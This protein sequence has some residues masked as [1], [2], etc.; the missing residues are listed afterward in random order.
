M[1]SHFRNFAP[2]LVGLFFVTVGASQAHAQITREVRAHLDHSFVIGNTTLPPG[3]Y[4]FQMAENSELSAMTAMSADGK[5]TVEFVVRQT[6]ADH[7]PGHSENTFRKYGN[8]EF[9]N[10]IFESGSKDGAQVT[11]TGRQEVRMAKQQQHSMEH[12]EV[13]K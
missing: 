4:T 3:D 8:V 6:T 9:L 13:Q 12:T 2:V 1:N 5:T 10:K 7:T 11:E